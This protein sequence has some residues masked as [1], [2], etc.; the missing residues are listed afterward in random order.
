MGYS[1]DKDGSFANYLS[2]PCMP[3]SRWRSYHYKK[4][5]YFYLISYKNFN[6]ID[7]IPEKIIKLAKKYKQ[8]YIVLNNSFE[9]Y[10]YMNFQFIYDFVKE[11]GLEKKIVYLCGHYYTEQ[12]YDYWCK[13][14]NFKNT[15]HTV[16]YNVFFDST[17]D[18]YIYGS[19][20][21]SVEKTK[22]FCCLNHRPHVHRLA[23]VTYMDYLDMLESGIVTCH[24][25]PYEVGTPKTDYDPYDESIK[26]LKNIVE[27]KYYEI[28]KTQSVKTKQKL[29]LVYDIHDLTNACQPMDFN[30]DIYN[31]YLINLVT[32]TFYTNHWNY[33]SEMFITEKT[34][35]PILSN[36]IF[37]II[38]PRGILK[39]L[40]E[41]GF[42][43]F[44]EFF[45][46]SYDSL[47][48]STRAFKAIET[49]KHVMCTYDISDLE[50]RTREIRAHNLEIFKKNK[51]N[52]NLANRLGI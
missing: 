14:N 47:P 35:K 10:A 19:T 12:E 15:Y 18:G 39:K 51:F 32:E 28:L 17:R 6:K 4:T 44:G 21:F 34:F 27:P 41:F 52:I 13:I 26:Y 43:T 1:N 24:D 42:R 23:A 2:I 9:G 29:P 46:E 38:G 25:R 31:N 20:T 7:Y 3:V 50:M 30:P 36:Q 45:D 33:Y 49:L 48:D 22:W 11:H 37:I 40:Q 5:P 8:F 16:S